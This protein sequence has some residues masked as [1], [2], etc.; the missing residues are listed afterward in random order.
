[1]Y[2]IQYN[3]AFTCDW[4]LLPPPPLPP[5]PLVP[6]APP[7]APPLPALLCCWW[8]A[9]S[10][11]LLSIC[12]KRSRIDILNWLSR[13]TE[14]CKRAEHVSKRVASSV[15]KKKK[16]LLLAMQ[17]CYSDKTNGPTVSIPSLKKCC[18]SGLFRGF[19]FTSGYCHQK[20]VQ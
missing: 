1:M 14:E 5:P 20:H 12:S 9:I 4:L 3:V 7:P 2:S 13:Q 19:C 6:P 11:I 10:A 18:Y 17:T 15:Q 8:L 16:K